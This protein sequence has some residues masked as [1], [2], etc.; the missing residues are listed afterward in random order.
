MSNYREVDRPPVLA[1][2]EIEKLLSMRLIANLA[3][4]DDDGGIHMVPMWFLRIADDIC[5]PTSR[6]THKYHNLRKRPSAS[7]MIDVSRAGLNLKGV[8][9]RGGVELIYG[10]EALRI[11]RSIHLKYLTPEALND[12]KVASY[13]SN[14]DDVTVKVNMDRIISW[15]LAD[16]SAGKALSVGG[17]FYPLNERLEST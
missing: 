4:I 8:L 9:I 6:N 10:E 1:P 17:W 15:N 3:T 13:L 11:N 7:V 2:A 16:S 12:I 5:I 14:G